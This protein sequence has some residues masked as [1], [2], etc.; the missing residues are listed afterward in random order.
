MP[1][2]LVRTVDAETGSMLPGEAGLALDHHPVPLGVAA[3][4]VHHL[5]L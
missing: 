2:Y 4:A 1:Q 5:P 3:G